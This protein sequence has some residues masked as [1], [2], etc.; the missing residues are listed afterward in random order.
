MGFGVGVLSLTI[1]GANALPSTQAASPAAAAQATG[2]HRREGR[3]PVGNSSRMK[4]ASPRPNSQ[5]QPAQLTNV[6][7][8]GKCARKIAMAPVA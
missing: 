3:C 2:R 7:A 8:A 1:L 4:T 6:S 5:I